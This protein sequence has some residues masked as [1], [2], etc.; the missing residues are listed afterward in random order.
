V[1]GAG[2]PVVEVV[3]RPDEHR[4]V[5]ELDGHVAELTYRRVA[6]R[7]VLVHTGVPMAIERRGI[8][9]A[10]V[11]AAVEWAIEEGLTVVPRCPF[12][13]AW[14]RRHPDVAAGA[15]IDWSAPGAR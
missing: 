15:L 4:F 11:R 12:A 1:T 3:R 7:L 6:A 9:S 5:V 13:A 14:L 10:L 8:G 2:S